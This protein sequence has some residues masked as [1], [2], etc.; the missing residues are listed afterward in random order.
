MEL[1]ANHTCIKARAGFALAQDYH[2]V[3]RFGM[4]WRRAADVTRDPSTTLY[5]SQ[6]NWADSLVVHVGVNLANRLRGIECF[7]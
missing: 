4:A 2:T 1:N 3:R 6:D 7:D 5:G